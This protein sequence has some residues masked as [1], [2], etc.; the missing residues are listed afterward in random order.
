MK[1]TS[2]LRH[3]RRR[4][5]SAASRRRAVRSAA[6]CRSNVVIESYAY[7]ALGRR[8]A[9][10]TA[11][12]TERHVYDDNWQ[13]IAD[14]DANGNVLRSYVWDAG[15]DRLLAV[16]IGSRTYTA[17][18]DVQGT[19]W[20]FSDEQGNVAALFGYDAWGNVLSRTYAPGAEALAGVRYGFQGR[21]HS[22]LTGFIHFRMRWYDP[23]TG[24]W[25][26]KDRIRLL[27]GMN[28]YA[29]CGE[30]PLNVRDSLGLCKNS[31]DDK[32]SD[33][34]LSFIEKVKNW[35]MAFFSASKTQ[36]NPGSGAIS[37]AAD[38]LEGVPSGAVLVGQTQAWCISMELLESSAMEAGDPGGLLEACE[39]AVRTGGAM[40]DA[41]M[42]R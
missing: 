2:I 19:V 4:Q 34:E 38:V 17:H 7:D 10:T 40:Q 36:L 39:K 21:E 8:V 18:T 35:V 37:T 1:T 26:S 41:L 30:N 27:G 5:A 32:D 3:V 16:K 33:S 28:L 25:L 20:A 24:R 23:V 13:V 9:T 22:R 6:P 42:N 31:S 12:G 14:L 11:N 15:I 29:F